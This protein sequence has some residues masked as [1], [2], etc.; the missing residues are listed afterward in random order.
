[1]DISL[2][3]KRAKE[4]DKE[5][6]SELIKNTRNDMFKV[7]MGI[8]KNEEDALDAIQDTILISY[9]NIE[10]ISKP[11]YFKTWIIKILINNSI[12]VLRKSEKYIRNEELDINYK[13]EGFSEVE[14]RDIIDKLPK[15]LKE[16]VKAYYF[17]D[18]SIRDISKEFNIPEGTVKSRLSRS[19]TFLKNILK[20]N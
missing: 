20:A 17:E 5:A 18:S 3:V 13:E 6:F 10:K 12:K 15:E 7:A 19:R 8:L 14:L 16:L 1:M 2:L 11:K 4:G 9:K